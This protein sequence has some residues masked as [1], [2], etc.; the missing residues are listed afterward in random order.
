RRSSDLLARSKRPI[1]F[2]EVGAVAPVLAAADEKHLDAGLATLLC[3][4]EYVCFLHAL[5]VDRLIRR[6]VRQRPQPVAQLGRALEFE[7]FGGFLRQFLIVPAD[8]LALTSEEA[9]RLIDEPVVVLEAD[10]AGA[11]RGATLD[12]IKQA[13]PRPRF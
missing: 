10:L 9:R 4:G 8:A 6:H 1:R 5:G 11:G 2:G 13:R 12:L 3:G 7:P